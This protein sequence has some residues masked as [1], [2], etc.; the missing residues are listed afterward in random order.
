[1]AGRPSKY[2]EKIALEIIK[3]FA[4]GEKLTAICKADSMPSRQSV[5]RWKLEYPEFNKAYAI[6]IE[7]H[8]EALQDRL[9][10]IVM[11]CD[12]KSFKSAKIKA[13]YIQW[14]CSKL[15]RKTFGDKIDL[16]VSHVLDVSPAL[17]KA[18]DRLSSLALPDPIQ[19]ADITPV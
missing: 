10:D 13:D 7:S 12:E 6:A 1:M 9:H 16:Q 3:R 14:F 2:N 19:E 18:L 5:F 17:K 15:N 4:S 11:S 8:T